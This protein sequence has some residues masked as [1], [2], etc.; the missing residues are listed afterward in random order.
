MLPKVVFQNNY[1]EFIGEVKQQV[2]EIALGA[3]FMPPC[4]CIFIDQVAS[5]FLKTQQHEALVG[6]K[7]IR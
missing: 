2:S 5:E 1:F 7:Y 3:K 6:C 4:A